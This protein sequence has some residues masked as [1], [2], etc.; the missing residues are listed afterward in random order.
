MAHPSD[1][2][3][4]Q[5]GEPVER[6]QVTVVFLRMLEPPLGR[7]VEWPA[8]VSVEKA[9]LSVAEYRQ[10]YDAV[11]HEWL[12][13]M[14]RL[15]P[16]DMLAEHLSRATLDIRLLKVNGRV[17]GFYELDASY[18]PYVNLNYFGLTPEFIGQGLGG[19]FLRHAV[20]A[21]FEGAV[22]LRGLLV[23]TCSA[24]HPRALPGYL[25]AG[26]VEY[27]R[28]VE[29]WDIPTRLGLAVPEHLRG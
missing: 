7:P 21:A 2:A 25:R 22:G 19:T 29:Q 23:N 18:W 9:S 24:D 15:M 13:W 17:A 6:V 5:Q 14:R 16:D 8:G 1:Y 27:R 20:L 11:G 10:I 12:W 26:F 28:E 4:P 3:R